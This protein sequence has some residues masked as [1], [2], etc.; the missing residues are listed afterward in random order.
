MICYQIIKIVVI[1]NNSHNHFNDYFLQYPPT[2]LNIQPCLSNPC[3]NEATCLS[4]S[5]SSSSFTC[6]CAANFTGKFCETGRVNLKDKIR[7]SLI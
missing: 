4:A 3:F 2:C 5:N 1:I 6:Q 7:F